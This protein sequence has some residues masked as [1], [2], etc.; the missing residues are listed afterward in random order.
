[1]QLV[2]GRQA[3]TMGRRRRGRRRTRTRRVLILLLW[4]RDGRE[5]G[6]GGW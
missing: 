2:I 6:R 3:S 4:R 1:M 5:G